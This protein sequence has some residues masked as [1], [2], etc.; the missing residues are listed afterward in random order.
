MAG[1]RAYQGENIPEGDEQND[2]QGWCGIGSFDT[3]H[4]K[5]PL[6]N[7]K[8]DIDMIQFYH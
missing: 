6:E 3:K 4:N 5:H 2:H 1:S 7:I 8:Q